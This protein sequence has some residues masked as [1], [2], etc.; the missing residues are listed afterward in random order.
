M[1]NETWKNVQKYDG[2]YQ[3]SNM[4]KLRALY[5]KERNGNRE[6]SVP[7]VISPFTITRGYQI[8]SLYKD[9]K[10]IKTLLHRLV[11]A[12]FCGMPANREMDCAHL[13]GNPKNNALVNLAWVTKKEN[14]SH[15]K[16]HGTD[17]SGEKHPNAKLTNNDV[18]MIRQ[19]LDSGVS[20]KIV[21]G[22]FGVTTH[23]IYRIVHKKQW[24][25]VL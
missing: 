25:S 8:V 16:I 3:V 12:T 24:A 11:L 22:K 18:R 5:R 9:G 7:L 21:A 19:L 2:K 15:R 23:T 20:R 13:D 10:Q 6:Y 1:T 14:Q 4:G 17:C